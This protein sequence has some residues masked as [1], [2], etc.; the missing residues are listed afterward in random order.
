M[1]HKLFKAA[2]LALTTVLAPVETV[3]QADSGALIVDE[4]SMATIGRVNKY[5][6]C[7]RTVECQGATYDVN[8]LFKYSD[9]LITF[10]LADQ[11]ALATTQSCG[12]LRNLE[13]K[14]G[15][16]NAADATLQLYG[17]A[18]PYHSYLDLYNP[19]TAGHLIATLDFP[20][21]READNVLQLQLTADYP[22]VALLPTGNNV[23]L[24]YLRF[25]WQPDDSLQGLTPTVASDPQLVQ[26]VGRPAYDLS[27]APA[28]VAAEGVVITQGRKTLRQS[29]R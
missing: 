29:T 18:T 4:V 24:R 14:W 12:F 27:G 3:A 17:S 23:H 7:Q 10:D 26:T 22:Y 8:A 15:N 13:V 28:G 9:N 21:D 5:T 16:S 19:A 11:P 6:T 20:T 2:L 25:T 1:A